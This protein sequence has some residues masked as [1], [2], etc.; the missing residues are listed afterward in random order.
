[1]VD[2]AVASYDVVLDREPLEFNLA[3]IADLEATFTPMFKMLLDNR[4]CLHP[5][6][7]Q[8]A[9]LFLGTSSR[10]SS[11]ARLGPAHLRARWCAG[12]GTGCR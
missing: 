12:R 9:S 3:Y 7:D 6:D 1:M 8:V 2:D 5:G 10:R 11:T 4:A